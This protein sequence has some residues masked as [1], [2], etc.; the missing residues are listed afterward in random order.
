MSEGT[1]LDRDYW[2]GRFQEGRTGW[3]IGHASPAL[4]NYALQFPLDSRILIPGAG[5]GYE[6]EALHR[7]GYEEL[8]LLD[9]A[10]TPIQS[11]RE[12]V[13][14]FPAAHIHEED[15]FAHEGKYDLILEQTF[16]C[17]LEREQR[18]DYVEKCHE[19]LEEGGILAGLLWA[20]D[21]EGGPPFG[22]TKEE[23]EALFEG[24][25]QILQLEEAKD[26]IPP[27]KGNELFFAAKK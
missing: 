21:W 9:L 24:R 11:F 14:D 8:H 17:A 5:Y 10:P 26:S 13:P 12:R 27:R 19:L 4:V 16:F 2:E 3:D 20:H 22:G 25:F 23:Y 7:K 1:P 15:F 18:A 6:G